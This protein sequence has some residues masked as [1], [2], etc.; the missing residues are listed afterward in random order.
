MGTS[1]WSSYRVASGYLC[2][3]NTLLHCR[4][5]WSSCIELRYT[6]GNLNWT[7]NAISLLQRP[8]WLPIRIFMCTCPAGT[9]STTNNQTWP[10]CNSKFEA[11]FNWMYTEEWVH[12][13]EKWKKRT[14]F[15]SI[16]YGC[17]LRSK[18]WVHKNG[19]TL[20]KV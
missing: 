6:A 16:I 17:S 18:V 14:N 4:P 15:L 10:A 5:W 9:L 1:S 7:T 8:M 3:N 11:Q 19:E 13:G 12:L 20:G 2:S